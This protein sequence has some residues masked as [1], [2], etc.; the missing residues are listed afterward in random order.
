M[1]KRKKYYTNYYI[2]SKPLIK[3]LPKRKLDNYLQKNDHNYQK[4]LINCIFYINTKS[5]QKSIFNG[6]TFIFLGSKPFD[7]YTFFL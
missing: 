1:I 7:D 2:I 6:N 3:K 5:C 4:S